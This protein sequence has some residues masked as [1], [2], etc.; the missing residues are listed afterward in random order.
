MVAVLYQ[1]DPNCPESVAAE[2]AEGASSPCLFDRA[3]TGP[4]LIPILFMARLCTAR[5]ADYH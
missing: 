2:Q 1:A 3:K 4:R 5:E